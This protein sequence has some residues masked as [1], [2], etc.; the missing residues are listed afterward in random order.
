MLSKMWSFK[1][2]TPTA[3]DIST[4]AYY[5]LLYDEYMILYIVGS[6][7]PD[8]FVPICIGNID[9]SLLLI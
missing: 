4:Y 8:V 9:M 1:L 3:D 6:E 7:D 5:I 2:C